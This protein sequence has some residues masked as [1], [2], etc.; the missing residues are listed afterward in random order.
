MDKIVVI[1]SCNFLDFPAGGQ[2]TFTKNLIS[3][4][5]DQIKLVGIVTDN[6]PIGEWTK[7]ELYGK[8]YE[9]FPFMRANKEIK[10]PKIP[11]RIKAFFSLK[12][13]KN[14]LNL[15]SDTRIFMQSPEMFLALGYSNYSNIC[16]R[17][18][19][20]ENFI[21]T[22]RYR[23]A[24]LVAFLYDKYFLPKLSNIR[25]I[26][27]TADNRSIDRLVSMS[28]GSLK[29]ENVKQFPTRV[30]T[31]I[32]KRMP[33]LSSRIDLNIPSS[34]T[35][36]VTTGRLAWY[37]GWKFM[38]DSF[39]IF[40]LNKNNAHLYFLGTGEDYNS[41]KSYIA[42]LKMQN[43]IHLIGFVNLETIAKYLNAADLFI[44]GSFTE[45]WSTSLIEAVACGT[46]ACVTNF[47]SAKEILE[48]GI[49]GYVIEAFEEDKFADLMN[50]C[51]MID[52]TGLPREVDSEKYS[53]ATLK[54][55]LTKL[56]V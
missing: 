14:R 54:S 43:S 1:E 35:M 16:Y 39:K 51:L 8:S 19:G 48:N 21:S 10:K 9:F 30:D 31:Q 25:L 4:F 53:I 49:N 32:F 24:R 38:I 55:D 28:G 52:R 26:L 6:S 45:G 12:K 7:L 41:I 20:T 46:P 17:F 27:A 23:L 34:Q 29:K 3:V 36:I 11:R 22:S 47:S 42:E 50:N 33:F 5:Q 2:L 44:M 18:P 13:Y 15:D 40:H 56:W 37:K